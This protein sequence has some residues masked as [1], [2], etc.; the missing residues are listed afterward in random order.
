M[1]ICSCYFIPSSS[2][3]TS[4]DGLRLSLYFVVVFSKSL[5]ACGFAVGGGW[6]HQRTSG[7]HPRDVQYLIF[8]LRVKRALMLALKSSRTAVG[9]RSGSYVLHRS[10]ERNTPR[11][12]AVGESFGLGHRQWVCHSGPRDRKSVIF[13]GVSSPG[14][15]GHLI[16]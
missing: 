3:V 11:L 12:R 6:S 7:M 4:R 16:R 13:S 5:W 1:L 9:F 8:V 10:G 15:G 2:C 14:L